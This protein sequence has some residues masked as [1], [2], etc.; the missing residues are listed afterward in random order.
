L[1]WTRTRDGG[2]ATLTGRQV[3]ADQDLVSGLA[4]AGVVEDD[5]RVLAAHLEGDQEFGP[6]E[7]GLLDAAA[8][9]VAAGEAQALDAVRSAS[10]AAPT[11]PVPRPG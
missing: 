9:R 4:D 3:A 5:R 10:S 6:I 7:G 8:D 2:G 1:A 11:A